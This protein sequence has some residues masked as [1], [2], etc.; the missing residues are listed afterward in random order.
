MVRAFGCGSGD[1]WFESVPLVFAKNA[2][3]F[4]VFEVNLR[5]GPDRSL[6]GKL[7]IQNPADLWLNVTF[8]KF[9]PKMCETE[10]HQLS[11]CDA[12]VHCVEKQ[13]IH[14]HANKDFF[15]QINLS[16]LP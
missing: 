11:Q 13:Q 1:R 15:F 14:C 9:L 6:A 7:L 8:T 5:S 16:K 4:M 3:F 10:L 12:C 2:D